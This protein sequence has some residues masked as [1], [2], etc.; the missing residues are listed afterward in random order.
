MDDNNRCS[1]TQTELKSED[2]SLSQSNPVM[3]GWEDHLLKCK[4]TNIRNQG[5]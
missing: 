1:E 2:L 5:S 4:D 3:S